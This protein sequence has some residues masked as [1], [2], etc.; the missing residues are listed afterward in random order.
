[1]S[2]PIRMY[3]RGPKRD[4]PDKFYRF[5]WSMYVRGFDYLEHCQ[6][7]LIGDRGSQIYANK[8]KFNLAYDMNESPSFDFLYI[9]GYSFKGYDH[10]LHAPVIHAPGESC[11]VQSAFDHVV[12][13]E[14]AKLVPIPEIPLGY[15]NFPKSYT[16]CRNW[17]C[18][19]AFYRPKGLPALPAGIL[20]K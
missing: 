3:V 8:A 13:F 6:M 2:K 10:N 4:K 12:E 14:N 17:C 9:H 18:A 16:T 19:L 11:Q 7:C 5:F 15:A 20:T 1:M